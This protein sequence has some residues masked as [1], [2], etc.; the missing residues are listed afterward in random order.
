MKRY[1]LWLRLLA[2]WRGGY[3]VWLTDWHG[4]DWPSIAKRI[5]N[6]RHLAPVF[7]WSQIGETFLEH[8][9]T[10]APDSESNYI[11]TWRRA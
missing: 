2:L 3:P 7:P 8:A 10:I 6:G 9:G 11:V 1:P 4:N 5:A